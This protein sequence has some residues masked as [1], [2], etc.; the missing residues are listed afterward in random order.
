MAID[1]INTEWIIKKIMLEATGHDGFVVY[2]VVLLDSAVL[3]PLA[4]QLK[5][6]LACFIFFQACALF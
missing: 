1:L 5:K 6:K 3:L 2:I 4:S